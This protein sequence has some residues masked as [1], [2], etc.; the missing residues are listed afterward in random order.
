MSTEKISI[1]E[2]AQDIELLI[3]E[4]GVIGFKI[5]ENLNSGKSSYLLRD[6]HIEFEDDVAY[7][8]DSDNII[9]KNM[10]QLMMFIK[11]S[12]KYIHRII[13]DG[14]PHGELYL[15]SGVITIEILE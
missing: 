8:W 2:L 9:M 12:I 7:S 5:S 15:N 13:I 14:V 1:E 10:H 6:L 11:S 3:W 4:R